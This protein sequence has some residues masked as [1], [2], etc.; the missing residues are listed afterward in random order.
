MNENKEIS[1]LIEKG[2]EA[3]ELGDHEAAA[4]FWMIAAH[5]E[6]NLLTKEENSSL[7]L[8]E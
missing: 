5:K 8:T 6:L 4:R 7:R 2:N 1:E 3:W